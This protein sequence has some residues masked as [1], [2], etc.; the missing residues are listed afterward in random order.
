[1]SAVGGGVKGSLTLPSP[2]SP[3]QSL[4]LP[5]S[6]QSQQQQFNS[7][8]QI[9]TVP[10]K[11]L[12]THSGCAHWCWVS[13][14]FFRAY[15]HIYGDR[16]CMHLPLILDAMIWII[17]SAS[18]A[19]HTPTIFSEWVIRSPMILLTVAVVLF[20]LG[21]YIFAFSSPQVC[22]FSTYNSNAEKYTSR[23]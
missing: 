21:L 6:L 23:N 19:S 11:A 20:S 16:Q 1:M 2:T 17:S 15:S 9:T 7:L 13:H 22:A 14:L 8:I 10:Y 5:S 18:P 12:W 4:L 3:T